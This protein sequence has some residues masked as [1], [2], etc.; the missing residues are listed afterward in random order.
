MIT[1]KTLSDGTVEFFEGED[2]IKTTAVGV[3]RHNRPDKILCLVFERDLERLRVSGKG[4]RDWVCYPN[5]TDYAA[6]PKSPDVAL[7]LP[8]RTKHNYPVT[9]V[10]HGIVGEM[11]RVES[12]STD[13]RVVDKRFDLRPPMHTVSE[14]T[15]HRTP[16]T[17]LRRRSNVSTLPSG[18]VKVEQFKFRAVRPNGQ[19]KEVFGDTI[20]DTQRLAGRF[21]MGIDD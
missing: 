8:G 3:G 15:A 13:P 10:I 12:L 1:S 9:H 19:S 14:P 17:S 5:Y 16:R 21:Q 6:V 11:R 7:K 2:I 20:E 18:V 4:V